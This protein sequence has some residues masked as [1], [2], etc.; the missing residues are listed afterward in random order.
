VGH[1]VVVGQGDDVGAGGLLEI[2]GGQD[3]VVPVQQAE[4]DITGGVLSP[5]AGGDDFD[6]GL[7]RVFQGEPDLA[8][9]AAGQLFVEDL[10]HQHAF[11]HQ[12]LRVAH[13]AG[14]F[15]GIRAHLHGGGQD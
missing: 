3:V 1:G 12:D 8:G 15:A 6:V 5:V 7:A 10:Q 2:R 13:D 4:H 14:G 9:G 11:A